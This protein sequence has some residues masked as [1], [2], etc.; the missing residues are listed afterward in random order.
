MSG[1]GA[2]A[3]SARQAAVYCG[4]SDK[5]IRRWIPMG[6][7][8]AE[9]DGRDFRIA[10][11]AL[12]ALRG[13]GRT[14][15][16]DDAVAA[17]APGADSRPAPADLAT[18]TAAQGAALVELVARQEQTSLELAGRVGWLPAQLQRRDEQ[19]KALLAPR[20]ER[21]TDNDWLAVSP[22]GQFEPLQERPRPSWGRR[23]FR[24]E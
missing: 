3:R 2:A 14:D 16:A 22:V 10:R 1:P 9:R 12:D 11:A 17:A 4:V 24:S 21:E 19:L 7:L 6:R 8:A 23:F 5:T 18:A 15:V 13:P 20:V